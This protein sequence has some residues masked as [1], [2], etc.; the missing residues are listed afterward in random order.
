MAQPNMSQP[1]F[2]QCAL[3]ADSSDL[4]ASHIIPG[5]VFDWLRETSATG[6]FRCS[7]SPNL[8]VQ[9]GWKVRMLCWACEQ[10]FSS[11]EKKFA[12][13]CFAPINGGRVHNVSYGPWMLKFATSVSWRVLRAYAASG[14]LSGFPDHIMTNIDDALQKWSRFLLGN[15]LHSSYLDQHLLLADVI[16][17]TSIPNI[18]PNI[19]RYLARDI[20]LHV[21]HN[22]DS[23]ISYAKMGRFIL[24]GFIDLKYPCYLRGT[25]LH[26]QDGRFGDHEKELPPDIIHL[27]FQRARL[28]A[29]KKRQISLRQQTKIRQSYERDPE[30]A[31]QSETLRAMRYD[32]MMFGKTAFDATQP[33]IHD[34]TTESKE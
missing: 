4:Q 20:D 13:E 28:S 29:E 9:D 24:F 8:R 5:F 3:C 10:R 6:H 25:K 31:T 18:P 12:E 21:A 26:V 22:Q 16:E 2:D 27:I 15:D 34:R 11:W 1:T 23:A 17:A 33:H 19:S 14:W 32:V 7:Q 30:R